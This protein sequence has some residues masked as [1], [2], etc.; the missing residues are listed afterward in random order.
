[1]PSSYVAPD[2]NSGTQRPDLV[3][4][5]SLVPPGGR[6]VRHWINPAA[7][8]KPAGEFGDAPRNLLRGPGTWQTDVGAAKTFL[9]AERA[10][11]EFRAEFYNIFNH[12]QL[13]QPQATFNP[14][15]HRGVRQHHQYGELEHSN[16]IANN[17][18]GLGNTARDPVGPAVGVLKKD[19]IEESNAGQVHATMKTIGW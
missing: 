9:L 4:G 16:R 6:N 7:F 11:L 8:A 17:A 1:M 2:G 5:V 19:A 13:G 10:Q 18:C 15:E 12:P 14:S 3:P